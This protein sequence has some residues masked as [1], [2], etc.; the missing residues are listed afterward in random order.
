M[1]RAS[2]KKNADKQENKTKPSVQTSSQG[3]KIDN[4]DLPG[5]VNVQVLGSSDKQTEKSNTKKSKHGERK[6]NSETKTNVTTRKDTTQNS[7]VKSKN[8]TG[9]NRERVTAS[10]IENSVRL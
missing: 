2:K 10:V 1:M 5:N 8:R 9:E 4:K 7:S 6:T 3:H